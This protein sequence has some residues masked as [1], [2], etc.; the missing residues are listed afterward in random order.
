MAPSSDA[1]LVSMCWYCPWTFSLTPHRSRHMA[2]AHPNKDR[3]TPTPGW[4]DASSGPP[5]SA[6]S[7]T[8]GEDD[9]DRADQGSSSSS[10]GSTSEIIAER[11]VIVVSDGD[12]KEVPNPAPAWAEGVRG[13]DGTDRGSI[14]CR[15]P[16]MT[17]TTGSISAR[18]SEFYG[19]FPEADNDAVTPCETEEDANRPSFFNT[20]GLQELLRFIVT[21][22]GTGLTWVEQITLRSV[23]LTLE[24]E[25]R[26]RGDKNNLRERLGTASALCTA[27]KQEERRVLATRG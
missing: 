20:V 14:A 2:A 4:R 25:T 1:A 3:L 13:R 6:V 11:F 8:D 17:A 16:R 5:A 15:A 12:Q 26:Q 21:G 7:R 23:L 19:R 18:I 27:V 22:G 24:P 9:G 10:S